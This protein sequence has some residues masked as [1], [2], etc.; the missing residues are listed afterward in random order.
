MLPIPATTLLYT[1]VVSATASEPAPL[2]YIAPYLERMKVPID[3]IAGTSIGAIVGA[4]YASGMGTTEIEKVI[5]DTD[6]DNI[7]KDRPPRKNRSIR[8][9]FDDRIF[10]IDNE[11]GFNSGEIKLPSGVVQGQK[12]QLLLDRLFIPVANVIDFDQLPTPFRAIATDIVTS[13]AVVLDSG[14]L[15]AW[16][17]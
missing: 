12:L 4:M 7:F 3:Y 14:S 1:I 16:W 8:R 6:W 17:W 9:K 2:Q 15:S 5:V 13:R 11:I 10:Q